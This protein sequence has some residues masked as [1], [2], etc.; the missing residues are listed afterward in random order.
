MKYLKAYGQTGKRRNQSFHR[1][2]LIL[3]FEVRLWSSPV[4]PFIFER[5]QP[6]HQ[7]NNQCQQKEG[8][9]GNSHSYNCHRQTEIPVCQLS[10][11]D[12]SFTY[13]ATVI[14]F[15]SLAAQPVLAYL[16]HVKPFR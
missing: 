12:S 7:A 10:S 8:E 16:L 5:K 3:Y 1:S 6:V 14:A 9:E 13:P 15:L 11:P 4:L 2:L